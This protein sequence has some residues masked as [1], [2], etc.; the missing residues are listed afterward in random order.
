M[1]LC[2]AYPELFFALRTNKMDFIDF[3]EFVDHILAFLT[4]DDPIMFDLNLF[5]SFA[6]K[7]GHT[8]VISHHSK[9]IFKVILV[10][11]ELPRGILN[12]ISSRAQKS[13]DSGLGVFF[14]FKRKSNRNVHIRNYGDCLCGYRKSTHV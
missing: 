13:V 6:W 11:C 12:Q 3:K 4:L 2:F 9:S 14:L 10:K 1:W 5:F 8:I 7:Y